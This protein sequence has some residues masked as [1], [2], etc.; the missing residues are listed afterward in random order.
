MHQQ[1][2]VI[3]AL[4]P[5]ERIYVDFAKGSAVLGSITLDTTLDVGKAQVV[6]NKLI[7]QHPLLQCIV[8]PQE[9]QLFFVSKPDF[10]CA[11]ELSNK[12]SFAEVYQQA[13]NSAVNPAESMIKCLLAQEGNQSYIVFLIHHCISDGASV[14]AFLNEFMGLYVDGTEANPYSTPQAIEAL[15]PAPSLS[16]DEIRQQEQAK[17][18][19]LEPIRMPYKPEME[20]STQPYMSTTSRQLDP[21]E[22]AKLIAESK[23][24]QFTVHGVLSAALIQACS[25]LAKGIYQKEELAL[26]VKYALDIRRRLPEPLPARQM[27]AAVTAYNETYAINK[28]VS[29]WELAKDTQK[30][31]HHYLDNE[32][33]NKSAHAFSAKKSVENANVALMISNIGLSGLRP[34]YGNIEVLDAHVHATV[35]APC[36]VVSILTVNGKIHL[37]FSFTQPFVP[38]YATTQIADR[39]MDILRTELV[40]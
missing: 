10:T 29:F 15:A 2:T 22:S 31:I 32:G 34:I 23:A 9:E 18:D 38:Q 21:Q 11:I 4:A 30:R 35:L 37:D 1:D 5:S 27:F 39:A 36:L 40:L 33:A 19:S 26:T 8:K 20:L 16:A 17:I 12:T 24:K 14:A 25:E 13:Q 6:L 3:R 7:A 28:T